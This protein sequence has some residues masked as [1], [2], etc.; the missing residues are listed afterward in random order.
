MTPHPSAQKVG[1]QGARNRKT[2][3]R[4]EVFAKERVGGVPDE[5]HRKKDERQ[6]LPPARANPKA[7]GRQSAYR[8]HD[9][10]EDYRPG[11]DGEE[12]LV[13]LRIELPH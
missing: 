2:D 1:D 12:G 5:I 4:P 6:P 7:D 9:E 11:S 8:G 13:S 3:Q 10:H